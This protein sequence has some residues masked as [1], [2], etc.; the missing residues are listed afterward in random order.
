MPTTAPP[1][2]CDWQARAQ[3]LEREVA[4]AVQENASLAAQVERAAYEVA[5]LEAQY[6]ATLAKLA[7]RKQG[8]RPRS[9]K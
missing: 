9:K 7:A 1:H 8:F 5:Q 3:E 6:H 2:E 4:A